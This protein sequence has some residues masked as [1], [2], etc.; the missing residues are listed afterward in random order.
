MALLLLLLLLL[1]PLLFGLLS[2]RAIRSIPDDF[3]D[4]QDDLEQPP[5]LRFQ[6]TLKSYGVVVR[7]CNQ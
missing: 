5:D 7:V 2:G 3:E 6:Q 1:T 4:L